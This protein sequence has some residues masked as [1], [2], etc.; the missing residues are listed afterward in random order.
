[1]MDIITKNFLNYNY[2]KKGYSAFKISQILNCSESR[3][4]YWL[5]KHGISKRSISEAIY[6]KHNP[7]GDPFRFKE[8]KTLKTAELLGF[9]LGL[10]WGEGTKADRNSVRLGNTDPKLIKK[11]IDFLIT[12]CNIYP[13]KL[14]FGLQVFSDIEP[15]TALSYW[16][17]ELGFSKDYFL[18]TI[19]VSPTQGKGTY[20]KKSKFGVLTIYFNNKKLRNM[21]INMLK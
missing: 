17:N 20:R 19:V 1:M 14:R 16:S 15:Q 7:N 3:V 8:P 9:G 2:I 21:L 5:N 18:P 10:Y 12:I 6:I 11:F 13:R 4:N